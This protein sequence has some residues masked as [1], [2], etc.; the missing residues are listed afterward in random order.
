MSQR[1]SHAVNAQ[2][3]DLFYLREDN[4]SLSLSFAIMHKICALRTLWILSSATVYFTSTGTVGS[5]VTLN[6]KVPQS[7]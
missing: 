6:F 5:S 2:S 1:Y 3:L 7:Q 4:V